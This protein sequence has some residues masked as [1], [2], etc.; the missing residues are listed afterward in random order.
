MLDEHPDEDKPSLPLAF[1]CPVC[2]GQSYS[3][4]PLA[5]SASFP[6]R[7]YR[8]GGCTLTFVDP[9]RYIEPKN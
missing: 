9:Q 3:E 8:C 2:K 5:G 1:R 7:L 6:I 4:V